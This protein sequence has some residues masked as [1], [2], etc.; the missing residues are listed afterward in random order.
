MNVEKKR[1]LKIFYLI[2]TSSEELSSCELAKRIGVTERTIKSDIKQVRDF[3]LDNGAVIKS[4]RG[5]GYWIEVFDSDKIQAIVEQLVIHFAYDSS[6]SDLSSEKR[7]NDILRKIIAQDGYVKLDDIAYELYLSRSSIKNEIKEARKVLESFNLGFETKPGF[8]SRIKGSEFDK[9]L[10]MLMLFEIYYHKAVLMFN[11][12]QLMNYFEC[13]DDVRNDIRHSFLKVLRESSCHIMDDYTQRIARYLILLRNRYKAKYYISFNPEKKVLL[14]SFKQYKIACDIIDEL[15]K[16][17]GYDVDEN[18]ILALEVFLL[19]WA[20]I[21]STS[22]L[23]GDYG[24]VYFEALTQLEKIS[25]R[26]RQEYSIEFFNC[27]WDKKIFLTGL[28]PIILKIKLNCEKND[29]K[30]SVLFNDSVRLSPLSIK[31]SYSAIE[32]LNEQYNT[33]NSFASHLIIAYRIYIIISK[34]KYDYSP[35]RMIICSMHGIEV[36]RSIKNSIINKYS[37]KYFAKL[38][39]YELY[40]MRALKYDDYDAVALNYPYFS[41]K[42]DWTFVLIELIPTDNQLQELYNKVILQGYQLKQFLEFFNFNKNFVFRDFNFESMESFINLISF[43]HGKESKFIHNIEYELNECVIKSIYNKTCILFINHQYVD[44]NI[45][46]IYQLNEIKNINGEEISHIIVL[47]V[48][49]NHSIKAFKFIEQ[50]SHQL[51]IDRETIYL[52]TESEKLDNI[53]D[54]VRKGLN[55]EMISLV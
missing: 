19:I 53:I 6:L 50:L 32:L 37:E 15:K 22:D 40:E 47:S 26:I 12:T 13:E 7:S 38:D 55:S 41:Y 27:E 42:Y 28:I 11:H 33:K 25:E 54:I 14:K 23:A 17:G 44:H 48:D 4:R 29:M 52:L 43:K 24:E 35:I 2:A 46:E 10:C 21:D 45:F 39:L 8:G 3:A 34:V 9:R 5:S 16:Y 20:D 30:S 1:V 36:A 51:V 31:L 49:F 18:E